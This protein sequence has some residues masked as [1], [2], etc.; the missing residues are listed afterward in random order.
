[1]MTLGIFLKLCE[2]GRKK[3]EDV[4]CKEY[5]VT[6]CPIQYHKSKRA[7]HKGI[8]QS[9]VIDFTEGCPHCQI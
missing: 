4:Y 2:C 9:N 5:F 3:K 8:K 7:E 6:L 1:M